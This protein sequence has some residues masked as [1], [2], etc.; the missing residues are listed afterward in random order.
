MPGYEASALTGI[1]APAGTPAEIIERLNREINAGFSDPA[2]QAR[3][4]DTGGMAVP[5]SP[6]EFRRL[7]ADETAKWARVVKESGA[8]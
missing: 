1:G 6:E 3:L 5:A 2:M 4:R 7:L 8:K